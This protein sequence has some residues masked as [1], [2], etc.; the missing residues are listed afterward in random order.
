MKKIALALLLFAG[1]E[2]VALAQASRSA[3]GC[4]APVYCAPN[5]SNP[6]ANN[7]GLETPR[8]AYVRSPETGEQSG[9][10][11]SY[12]IRGPGLRL[13]AISIELPELRLGGLVKYRR[14]PE[15]HVEGSRAPWVDGRALEFNQVPRN[16]ETNDRSIDSQPRDLCVPPAPACT[17]ATEKL[18]REE[19]ARKESEIRQ[20]HE[21]FG[22]LESAVNRLAESRERDVSMPVRRRA[23]AP[24]IV[25][26]GYSE[27]VYEDEY[28]RPV[29]SVIS[30]RASRN[31]P[32]AADL[33]AA[34]PRPS[35]PIGRSTARRAFDEDDDLREVFPESN[36]GFSK[37]VNESESSE[38]DQQGMGIWKGEG[39]G[40]SPKRGDGS[41]K[42][43]I[44]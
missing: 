19:I 28:P 31:A 11:T 42:R 13:P 25:E 3:D 5:C 16:I 18:L 4:Q 8:G 1:A 30:T 35:A 15:M 38:L 21:R 36:V 10:S 17:T 12:G 34:T 27:D 20:M 7:R 26:A 44:R 33:H 29:R 14:N 2:R 39:Q 40:P 6:P 9:E 37:I 22:Q 43:A 41:A 32:V 24:T 23:T